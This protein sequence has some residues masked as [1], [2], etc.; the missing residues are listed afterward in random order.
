[1]SR[2]EIITTPEGFR[3]TPLGRYQFPQGEGSFVGTPVYRA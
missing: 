1:M 3:D 2:S